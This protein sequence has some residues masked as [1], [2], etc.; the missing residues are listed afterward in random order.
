M[1]MVGTVEFL[2]I[3]LKPESSICNSCSYFELIVR[4]YGHDWYIIRLH[5]VVIRCKGDNK[6]RD[7]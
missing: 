3:T 7:N 1:L 6:T 2:L 5:A 4:F